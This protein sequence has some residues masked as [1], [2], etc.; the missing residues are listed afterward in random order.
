MPMEE[1]TYKLA[2]E[3]RKAGGEIE[4]IVKKGVGHHP[5]CLKDPIPIINFIL[6]NSTDKR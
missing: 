6:K 4:I 2:E 3:F 5:H 1:N